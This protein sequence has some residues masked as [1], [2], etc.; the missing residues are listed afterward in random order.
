MKKIKSFIN[1]GILLNSVSEKLKMKQIK[2]KVDF[3]VSF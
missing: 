3:L 2:I 1:W